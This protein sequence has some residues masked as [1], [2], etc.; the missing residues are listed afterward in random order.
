[1]ENCI[2]C[3]NDQN[4]HLNMCGDCHETLAEAMGMDHMAMA[5]DEMGSGLERL[6]RS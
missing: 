5:F 3:G 2:N 1:M 6:F 4:V